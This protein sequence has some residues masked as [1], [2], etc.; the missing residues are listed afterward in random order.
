MDNIQRY[1]ETLGLK[2]GATPEE[3]KQAYRDLVKVWHPD[4][5]SHDPKLQRKAQEKLKEINQ[6][7]DQLLAFLQGSGNQPNQSQPRRRSAESR[8]KKVQKPPKSPPQS[9]S[10]TQ[11]ARKTAFLVQGILK[12]L[13]SKLRSLLRKVGIKLPPL[14]DER[15]MMLVLL[16]IAAIYLMITGI[17]LMG[18]L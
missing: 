7:Y 3:V 8:S 16:I 14:T 5:F 2:P 18:L 11:A 12:E 15:R 4:R 9:A 10:R 1:Y 13:E 17:Y 6:T